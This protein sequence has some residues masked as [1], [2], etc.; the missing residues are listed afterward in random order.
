MNMNDL[1]LFLTLFILFGIVITLMVIN[2][3][4]NEPMEAFKY[5]AVVNKGTKLETKISKPMYFVYSFTV[6]GFFNFLKQNC[7]ITSEAC[8]P[9]SIDLQALYLN[10]R[11]DLIAFREVKDKDGKT[12]MF[13]DCY[14]NN[15][16]GEEELIIQDKRVLLEKKLKDL[17]NRI[18]SLTFNK[19]HTK[20]L[21]KKAKQTPW[22]RKKT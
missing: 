6:D 15:E 12:K 2:Y 5:T 4:K 9:R 18:K 14:K 19:K 7:N 1:T 13:I 11:I 21:N 20:A 16:H 10:K 8:P 3:L 17:I 22:K